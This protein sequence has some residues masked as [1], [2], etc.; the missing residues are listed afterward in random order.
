[1]NLIKGSFH[2]LFEGSLKTYVIETL[3]ETKGAQEFRKF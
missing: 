2:A 3:E 1:M